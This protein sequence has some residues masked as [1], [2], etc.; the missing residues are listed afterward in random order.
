MVGGWGPVENSK[1]IDYILAAV[2][3][4]VKRLCGQA[5]GHLI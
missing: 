4:A 1:K 2:K 5:I 3:A